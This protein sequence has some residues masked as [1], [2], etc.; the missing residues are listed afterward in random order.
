MLANES[1]T[2]KL[3][4]QILKLQSLVQTL[5]QTI[6]DSER[7]G[8]ING[9]PEID[10]LFHAF[11][12]LRTYV[13]H[14]SPLEQF[15]VKVVAVIG[16]G[17]IVFHGFN[18]IKNPKEPLN[19][20]VK[21]LLEIEKFYDSL[22]GIAGYQLIVLK[23]LCQKEQ[24]DKQEQIE[25]SNPP[26][27]DIS[28]AG[29]E[30]D[31]AV[32]W[33]I[34]SMH[35][36]GEMYPIGGA[37]DR[38]NLIDQET[39]EPLPAAQLLFCG[40]T[41]LELLIRDLQGREFLYYKLFGKQLFTPLAIMTSHE[42]NNHQR[43]MELCKNKNWFGRSQGH[44][45]FFIQPLVPMVTSAGEWMICSP[46]QLM[47]KPGGHG[48]IWKAALDE[49]IFDWFE[50][51]HRKKILVRQINNPIAGIDSSLLAFIGIGCEKKK[52]FGFASCNR[53][54]GSAEGMNVLRE[55]KLSDGYEYCISNIE[56]TEFKKCGIEDA[57]EKPGSAYSRFPANTNIL[58]GDLSAIRKAV[59]SCPI[60]GMLINLKSHVACYPDASEEKIAGR[61]EST[62]QNIADYI[63]DKIPK[64]LK[65]N[66]TGQLRTFL[67]Y[68]TRKKTISVAK[69]AYEEGKLKDTPEECFYDLLANYRDLLS[70]HCQMDLPS[71][72]DEDDYMMAGPDCI[73][74]FH[75]ALGGLY[76]VIKQ[77][78]HGGK[79]AKGSEWILEISEA[80]I[81]NLDLDGSLIIEAEAIVGR[82]NDQGMLA[83]DEDHCGKCTLINVKVRNQGREEVPVHDVWRCQ[84][85]RKE[86]LHIT[87]RGNAEFFAENVT[88]EGD[89]HF[90]VPEEHRLVVY[91]QGS[92]IAWHYEKIAKPSWKWEYFLEDDSSITLE[93]TKR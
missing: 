55:T 56:Y 37:G 60:P 80:H 28:K 46:M 53:L 79:L 91:Q 83:F 62:M 40:R 7:L 69:Q 33:G 24:C 61:L 38:L 41:L 34:E 20:L 87:L 70:N 65:N 89:V 25:Y 57:P 58:F 9:R 67:T 36:M 84:Y 42:K 93:K 32:R 76:S 27:I 29:M 5:S 71:E 43:I 52:D 19:R 68:N 92:E 15:V 10:E 1:K 8:I 74:L 6:D 72:Q 66:E 44:Y 49:G 30:L 39:G 78:I 86:A 51:K 59:N 35:V 31:Q 47:L 23:L 77:K 64:K 82:E 45:R 11:P 54:I 16:Q 48:V 88:L 18:S 50:K 21:H 26:E 22:G 73:V 14:L 63:V 13:E 17:S 75:P 81:V 3:N 12:A 2:S 85:E 90:D 4:N